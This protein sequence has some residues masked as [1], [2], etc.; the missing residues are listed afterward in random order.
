VLACL[1]VVT[2]VWT[3]GS[4]AR[5]WGAATGGGHHTALNR[6]NLQFARARRDHVTED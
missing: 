3:I 4:F 5:G 2:D 1:D 6:M